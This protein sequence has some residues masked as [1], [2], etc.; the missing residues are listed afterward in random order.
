MALVALLI[1]APTASAQLSATP[2]TISAADNAASSVRGGDETVVLNEDF[3][4]E[5]VEYESSID[6]YSDGANDF[7]TRTDGSNISSSYEVFGAGGNSFFAAQDIDRAST[8][9]PLQSLFFRQVEVA[10]LQDLNLSFR[11]AEDDSNDGA[12]D[13]DATDHFR[14]Y[15]TVLQQGNT[16]TGGEPEVLVFAIESSANGSNN[17]PRVDT[18]FDGIGDGAE[19]TPEFAQFNVSLPSGS[20]VLLRFEFRLDAGDEDIAIDDVRV[21]GYAAPQ[22][23]NC[24]VG[25]SLTIIPGG[26]ATGASSPANGSVSLFNDGSAGVLM[27]PCTLGAFDPLSE[28][29]TF[30][31]PLSPFALAPGASAGF[32]GSV[33]A[34]GLPD[35]PGAV[36]LVEGPIALG[37]TIAEILPNLVSGMVY[38]AEDDILF[39]YRS[40]AP[41]VAGFAAA[42]ARLQS[43]TAGEEGAGAIALTVD[44]APNPLR[45]RTTVTF[46]VGG[47]SNVRVSVYDALGREVAVLADSRYSAGR[48]DVTFDASDLPTG[49]YVIRADLGTETQTTRVTV[50]R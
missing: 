38:Q 27:E 23:V 29:A 13:W 9:D 39:I 10:G 48:H 20:L 6:E 47:S 19:L 50:T 1:L 44:V 49:V 2:V 32:V 26:F 33:I 12:E 35:G 16:L 5:A 46:G 8:Y 15:A 31:N 42:V 45:D 30:S 43:P 7:F 36:V 41:D 11:L 28:L 34:D 18:D 21:T 37:A 14:I 17:A 24:A 4:N 40:D 25:S 3:E 22:T